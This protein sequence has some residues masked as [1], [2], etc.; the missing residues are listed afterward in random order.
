MVRCFVGVWVSDEVKKKLIETQKI[1]KKL[2]M[3]LKLVEPE[4]LHISLSFL[5]EK[6]DEELKLIY[7]K[8]DGLVKNYNSFDVVVGKIKLIPS[9]SYIRVVAFDLNNNQI[10]SKISKEIERVV[11]GSVKPPHL[12][13]CRVKSV[14]DKGGVKKIKSLSVPLSFKV[15][16][17]HI[18]ESRLTP[19]GPI[20]KS[21]HKSRLA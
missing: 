1:L 6:V 21:I 13:L 10:L 11:G 12:T 19:K 4:N 7:D 17:I 8:M 5:G 15:D 2:S 14:E 20:Y 3:K 9:D 16:A 18:I